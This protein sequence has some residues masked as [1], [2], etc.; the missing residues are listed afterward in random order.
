MDLPGEIL[1]LGE[2]SRWF[3]PGGGISSGWE[4]CTLIESKE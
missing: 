3:H 2:S 4:G 1:L